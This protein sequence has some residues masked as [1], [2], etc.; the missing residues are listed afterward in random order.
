MNKKIILMVG[1]SILLIGIV[2]A[3]SLSSKIQKG[4]EALTL[5]GIDTNKL[6]SVELIDLD[7]KIKDKK[8]NISSGNQ[9]EGMF[10]EIDYTDQKKPIYI[11][12]N[13]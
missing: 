2:F 1:I 3:L 7:T 5:L 6:Q 11:I 8:L 9:N 4:E 13:G 12:T 10:Y